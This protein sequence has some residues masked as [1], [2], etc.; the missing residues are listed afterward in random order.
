MGQ[1]CTCRPMHTLHRISPEYR[2]PVIYFANPALVCAGRARRD[3]RA[4]CFPLAGL[5]EHFEDW[6]VLVAGRSQFT[7]TETV[8]TIRDGSQNTGTCMDVT[9]PITQGDR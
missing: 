8:R 6:S 2:V 9:W 7:S 4:T 1:V 5:A 3:S